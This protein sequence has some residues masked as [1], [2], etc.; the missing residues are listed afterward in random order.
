MN[1]QLYTFCLLMVTGAALAFVF[2]CYRVTRNLLRWRGFVTAA[3]DLLYWLLAAII[4]FLVLLKGN[5]GEIRFFVFL[6]LILGAALYCRFIS[7]YAVWLLGTTARA[8]GRLLRTVGIVVNC[9]FIR[10][11]LLPLRWLY[12]QSVAAGKRLY[13]C[14]AIAKS[15][16][17][18][19]L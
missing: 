10:P 13:R 19:E 14:L 16:K 4:V 2:D 12:R 1:E 3:A 7:A 8:I 15:G 11:W 9:L 18:P 17:P 5:W 6:A